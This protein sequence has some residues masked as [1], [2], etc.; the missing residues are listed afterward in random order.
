MKRKYILFTLI[1]LGFNTLWAFTP[2]EGRYRY[3]L[4]VRIK[5]S[6]NFSSKC[7]NRYEF[8]VTYAGSAEKMLY[9][10]HFKGLGINKNWTDCPAYVFYE[11]ASVKISKLKFVGRRGWKNWAGCNNNKGTSDLISVYSSSYPCDVLILGDCVPKWDSYAT[12]AISPEAIHIYYHDYNGRYKTSDMYLTDQKRI[13][14]KATTGFAASAYLW[15]YAVKSRDG[16]ERWE[17]VTWKPVPASYCNGSVASFSGNELM[18]ADAFRKVLAEKKMVAVQIKGCTESPLMI[19]DPRL[20]GPKIVKIETTPPSCSY[21]QD[22]KFR[23]YFDRALLPGEMAEVALNKMPDIGDLDPGPPIGPVIPLPMEKTAVSPAAVIMGGRF[24]HEESVVELTGVSSGTYTVRLI[25]GSYPDDY[26]SYV[27]DLTDHSSGRTE[28]E[29]TSDPELQKI[30]PGDVSCYGGE[31]G[32]ITV[33]PAG[34]RGNLFLL[35]SARDSVA[36]LRGAETTVTGLKTGSYKVRLHGLNGCTARENDAEKVWDVVISQPAGPVKVQQYT[37]PVHPSGYGLANGKIEVVAGGGSGGYVYEWKKDNILQSALSGNSSSALGHGTYTVTVRD[38]RYD[39]ALPATAVNRAGCMGS[40][41]IA[42]KQPDPLT[43]EITQEEKVSCY[44][45]K[46]AGLKAQG[47]GGV[48]PYTWQW[49]YL[50]GTVW[51]NAVSSAVLSDIGAGSYRAEVK[52]KNNNRAFSSVF[53]VT[54]P[55]PLKVQLTTEMPKCNGAADGRISAAV[56]GGTPGY[57]YVWMA[58]PETA[59]AITAGEGNY[60]VR[61]TDHNGCQVNVSAVLTEPAPLVADMQLTLPSRYDA[62]DGQIR[63]IPS[64]GTPYAGGSYRYQWNYKGMTVNPLTGLPADSVPYHVTVKDAHNCQVVLHP[65]LIYPIGVTIRIKKPVSCK[66][67]NDA[68]LEAMPSGGVSRHYR[69]EWYKSESGSFR[70]I[71]GNGKTSVPVGAGT[72]RVKVTDTENNTATAEIAVTEPALLQASARVALPSAASASDGRITISASG[73]TPAYSYRWDYRNATSNPL[74]GLPADSVPYHVTVKDAH[75]CQVVLHPRLIYPIGVTIRVKKPVS[76]KG[77]NDALLEAVPS[78]GV[79]RHYRYEWY[80]SEDGSFCSIAGN[81]KIS[82]P[83][84]VGTYRVKVT[85]T[86]NNTASAD[87]D[88]AEPEQLTA[89]YNIEIPSAPSA[90][91]GKITLY[92]AGGTP[93]SDGTYR[94]IWDYGE[95]TSNPLT[96]LPADSVPYHVVVR[97]AR[98]CRIELNPRILYPLIVHLEVKDSISCYK[99]ADGRLKAVADGGVSRHY[100]YTWYRKDTAGFR[101]IAGAEAL[102]E[103]L[104]EGIYR[105]KILDSEHNQAVSPEF[106]FRHPD[107]LRLQFSHFDPLCKDDRNGWIDVLVEGGTNPYHYHWS[108]SGSL[109]TG[110]REALPCGEYGLTVTDAHGCEISSRDT[111]T[112]PDSLLVT[113]LVYFPSVYGGSDGVIRLFPTGGTEPYTYHWDYMDAAVNPLTGLAASDVPYGVTVTDA[114]GCTVA[115]TPRMYNPLIVEIQ[116]RDSISCYGRA[117]GRLAAVWAGGVGAPYHFEWF[118]KENGGFL[119]VGTDDSILYRV[120]DGIYRVKIRDAIDSMAFS[121]EFAFRHP[122]ALE[123]QF[124]HKFPLCKHDANGWTEAVVNG[125][126]TPYSYGWTD[127]PAAAPA[128]RENLEDGVY[129]VTVT[130]RRGCRITASDTLTEPDSLILRYEVNFPSV[131]GGSDGTIRIMPEGGTLPYRYDWD[132]NHADANPLC[133]LS[134]QEDPLHVVVTDAHGCRVTDSMYMYDPV[135]LDIEESGVIICSGQTNAELTAHVKGGAGKPYRF[136]WYFVEDDLLTRLAGADSLLKNVGVGTYRVW[137]R[138][139][140]GNAGCSADYTVYSPDSLRMEFETG[141]LPCKYDKKGWIQAIPLGG[142]APYRIEWSHGSADARIE[143]LEEGRYEVKLTDK[144]GC[145]INRKVKINSPDELLL[146]IDYREPLGWERSDGAVWVMPEGGTQPYHYEWQGYEND[147]DT[148]DGIPAGGYRVTV[149]DNHRCEKTISTLV[150]QPSLLEVTVACTRIISCFGVADGILEAS[151]T[152]GVGNY[153]YDWFRTNAGKE[154]YISSG[155]VCENIPAGAYRVRVTDNNGIIAWSEIWDLTQPQLLEAEVRASALLC[156]GDTDGSVTAVVK[157]GTTPYACLWT[158]GDRTETVGNLPEG[159]YLVAVKDAHGCRTE[160]LGTIQ[161][162]EALQVDTDLTDPVCNGGT[163][164]IALSISG[165]TGKYEILWT[166]G[167]RKA[168]RSGLIAGV[169]PVEVT[170]AQGCLWKDTL[171]LRQPDQVVVDLGEERTLCRDQQYE[172]RPLNISGIARYRWLKDGKETG[173]A[174]TLSVSEAGVYCLEVET[175][176]GCRGKGEVNIRKNDALIDANFAMASEVEE[177]VVLKVINTSRPMPSYCRWILPDRGGFEVV[178]DEEELLELL[179][180]R[181]GYYTVGLRSEEGACEQ[182]LYKEVS[183]IPAGDVQPSARA[184]ERTIRDLRAWPVPNDGNFRVRITL[185][186]QA[187]GRLRLYAL[188]GVMIREVRCRGEEEYEF[189]FS[190]SLPAGIYI[191]HA[192]FGRERE[193]LKMVV[194]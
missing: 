92:P 33:Q 141:D 146:D 55:E 48:A 17:D 35:Y 151:V 112:E 63:L 170:D 184:G 44:G 57:S 28:V 135:T 168:K 165:G 39:K 172:L 67:D 89:T 118:R 95:A 120:S 77:D 130:D 93:F 70:S 27:S 105:V 99:R 38:S 52:D 29:K 10:Q 40:V 24:Q 11:K 3:E 158:S 191:I 102:S 62:T 94:Y 177:G 97:D 106:D 66:G 145:F 108:D 126:I 72:Y 161:A 100:S 64:G 136:A 143:N 88:L 69:Y 36:V 74:T 162:P 59:S 188:T 23:I 166:D 123:L 25:Q 116:V 138:D 117:D 76:C 75:N 131:Y 129:R 127:L 34:G 104:G 73:G 19:M 54:Q 173:S 128:L 82:V 68:L 60:S 153:R 139:S 160:A 85:D 180:D 42:L 156:K 6:N 175:K 79:S 152:G 21:T 169:Y 148:L 26:P 124:R 14:L 190:E 83:V 174:S 111:L 96:A 51:R 50:D 56:T 167:S 140:V 71:A 8:Y 15:M 47:K 181:T 80:K 132:Y 30:T 110:R 134:A 1:L 163:G 13:T 20:Y 107:T 185:S 81:G 86:E 98:D 178:R 18:G 187:D 103:P 31:N 179:F 150:P 61:V 32:K 12:L 4:N 101:E 87:Y 122:D 53:V 142:E 147:R 113:H 137:A 176:K 189:R 192:V 46:D 186:K 90:A 159:R 78:G 119:P 65:R 182:I 194:E 193:A 121:A 144:R 149:T 109:N 171:E 115:D 43:A 41:S 155:K 133:G 49:Q 164:S 22:G 2:P 154:E 45:K 5:S 9:E 58:R 7:K 91:D 84:G 16:G 114:H 183:V 157:G 125:G 37:T